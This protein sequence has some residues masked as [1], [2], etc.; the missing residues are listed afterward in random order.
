MPLV[1]LKAGA[2]TRLKKSTGLINW[3][4]HYITGGAMTDPAL[5]FPV[6]FPTIGANQETGWGLAQA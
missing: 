4:H 5:M 1:P 3:G 2:T 6:V